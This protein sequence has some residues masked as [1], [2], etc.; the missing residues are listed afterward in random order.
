M[1][2]KFIVAAVLA[3]FLISSPSAFPEGEGLKMGFADMRKMFYDYKKTKDF[4]KGLE[5]EDEK[6]KKELA[7]RSEK[8]KKLRDELGLLSDEAK[9][10]K[11]P[12]LREEIKKLDDYRREKI[13]SFVQKKDKMFQEIR[14]DIMGV[15]SKYAKKNKYDA[16]LDGSVFVYSS[17]EYDLTDAI[18]KELNK[19]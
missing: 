16:I 8:I 4:N 13:E 19:K 7:K 9:E 10:K 6:V 14:D 5:K 17:E 12:K 18:L 2:K 11:E 1:F 3:A 15:A